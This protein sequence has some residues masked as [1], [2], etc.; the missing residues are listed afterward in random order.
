[1]LPVQAELT[2]RRADV[3]LLIHEHEPLEAFALLDAD[4]MDLALTYDYNLAP[5][6]FAGRYETRPLWTV[7]WG[8]GVPP[9]TTAEQ[10]WH[11]D[12]IVNSRNTAD[13]V[14]VRT[15]AAL[16]GFEARIVHRCDSLDL[17][18]DLIV[19]GLG[20]GLLP[21]GRPLTDGVRLLPL[22]DPAVLL[23]AYA[24]T[25]RGRAGWPPLALVLDLLDGVGP[26]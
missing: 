16:S 1:M 10:A 22:S 6:R 4:D 3:R 25:R 5:A 13:E 9:G 26:R 12:W 24:V 14:V 11:R 20:V 21:A 8:L 17:V 18:E 2:V 23:R 15:L 19:A 7:P